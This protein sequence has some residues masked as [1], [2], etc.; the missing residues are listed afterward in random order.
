MQYL[1]TVY[2]RLEPLVL[3]HTTLRCDCHTQVKRCIELG[4][5]V[6]QLNRNN[7]TAITAVCSYEVLCCSGAVHIPECVSN[8]R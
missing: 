8:C 3:L 5:D 7:A 6:N 4:I 1:L 2:S